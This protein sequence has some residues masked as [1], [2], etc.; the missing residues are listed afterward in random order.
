MEYHVDTMVRGFRCHSNLI[1]LL[2]GKVAVLSWCHVIYDIATVGTCSET[3]ALPWYTCN[4]IVVRFLIVLWIH[5]CVD[6]RPHNSLLPTHSPPSL[7]LSLSLSLSHTHTHSR[8]LASSIRASGSSHKS[9][10]HHFHTDMAFLQSVG[11]TAGSADFC[12]NAG[13]MFG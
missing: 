5:N 7:S 13:E 10:Q 1:I 4:T 9:I 11:W 6:S 3:L 12:A 8:S 2:H